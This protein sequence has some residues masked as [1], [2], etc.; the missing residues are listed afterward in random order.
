MILNQNDLVNEF[1]F[2]VEHALSFGNTHKY[3]KT[4]RENI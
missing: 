3:L 1:D 2:N 4:L